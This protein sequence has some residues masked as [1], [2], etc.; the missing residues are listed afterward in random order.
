MSRQSQPVAHSSS[1]VLSH[2]HPHLS[3]K[4]ETCLPLADTGLL[5]TSVV[6]SVCKILLHPCQPSVHMGP[7]ALSC[8]TNGRAQW[9]SGGFTSSNAELLVAY[10]ACGYLELMFRLVLPAPG[11]RN[12]CRGCKVSP[13]PYR[14][15]SSRGLLSQWILIWFS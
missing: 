2:L 4:L 9:S 1:E 7:P 15:L 6:F 5:G 14:H 3:A 8:C 13:S 12:R 11:L 10:G